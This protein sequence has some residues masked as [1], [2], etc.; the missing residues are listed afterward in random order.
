[1]SPW[2]IVY[3]KNWIFSDN[4][5]RVMFG[6]NLKTFSKPCYF[7]FLTFPKTCYFAHSLFFKRTRGNSIPSDY[8]YFTKITN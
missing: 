5:F 4:F 8:I 3:K 7:N 1:M 6:R 2:P